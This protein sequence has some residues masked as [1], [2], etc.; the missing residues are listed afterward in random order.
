M[1]G[2]RETQGLR[3]GILT[4]LILVLAAPVMGAGTPGDAGLLSLRIGVGARE[5]GMG[6]AGVASSRGA[7]AIFW[8]PANNVFADFE[9]SLVL[10]HHRYLGLFNHESAAVAHRVGKGVLG[11]IFTG[12]YSD[13][14]ERYGTDQVGVSQ[15]SFKPYDVAFGVSYAHPLGESF[16]AG[17]NAK[18]LYERID[19]YSDTGFAF[20]FFL[21]HKAMIEGL[22]FAASATNLGGKVNLNEEPFKLPTAFRL[23]AAWTP[24]SDLFKSRLSITGDVVFPNDST[25]KAHLGAEYQLIPEFALRLGTRVNYEN[26]GLTAGAGF[27][28]GVLGVDYAYEESTVEGFNDGH[29]FSLNL[30][31]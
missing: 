26:Q 16:A 25:E 14:I 20:D 21:T 30:V 8:N 29:K 28:T 10:Q 19:I 6:E 31:W 1:V 13:S 17:I 18:F 22:V 23:G 24:D 12:F 9:T 7:S 11:F 15:G 5:A 27:R 2:K 4:V 3:R